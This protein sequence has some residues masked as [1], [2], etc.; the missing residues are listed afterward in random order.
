MEF[1]VPMMVP[2]TPI[3]KMTMPPDTHFFITCK[4]SL[5][6]LEGYRKKFE[7]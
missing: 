2:G 1:C 4:V 6:M 5:N 7:F 3:A